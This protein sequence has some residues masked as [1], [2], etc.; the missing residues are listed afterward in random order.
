MVKELILSQLRESVTDGGWHGPSLLDVV[1]G[2]DV[3]QAMAKPL[4]DRHT[5]GEIVQHTVYWMDKV[6]EVLEGG[7]HP[8]IGD[9]EDWKPVDE[10]RSEWESVDN[11]IVNAHKGLIESLHGFEGD[12][13]AEVPG[14][15][16]SYS[17]ML[18]GLV[19]HNLYHAGQIA[20]LKRK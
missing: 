11:W 13:D 20:I 2:V 19:N 4:K 12:L 8:P 10:G 15:S 18:F 5:I 6:N 1:N 7:E 16:F 14:T 3:S 17:W 9:P